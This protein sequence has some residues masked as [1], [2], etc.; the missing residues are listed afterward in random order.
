MRLFDK[1]DAMGI[2]AFGAIFFNFGNILLW[3]I[4]RSYLPDSNVLLLNY[5]LASG[6]LSLFIAKGYLN[7]IDDHMQIINS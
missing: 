1:Y 3:T 7:T 4:A 5:G 2:A 6:F